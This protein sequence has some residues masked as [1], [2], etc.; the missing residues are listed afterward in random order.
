M[1]A[2][3]FGLVLSGCESL[4]R[5]GSGDVNGAKTARGSADSPGAGRGGIYDPDPAHL[6]NRLHRHLFVRVASDGREQGLDALDPFLWSETRYLI[7]GTAHRQAIALL[8]EFL[9]VRGERLVTDALK[10]ALLQRDLLAVYD[11]LAHKPPEQ[12]RQAHG[13]AERLAAVIRRVTLTHAEAAALP[14]NY[15]AAVNSKAFA[16]E[17]QADRPDAP[18]LPGD[19]LDEEGSWVCVGRDDGEQTASVHDVSFAARSTFLVF[20]RLPGGRARTLEYLRNL[21][22]HPRLWVRDPRGIDNLILNA[23]APQFPAGTQ[24]AL[25]R[26]ALLIDAGGALFQSPLTEDVQLRFYHAQPEGAASSA[27]QAQASQFFYE[28]KLSREKLFAGQDGGLRAVLS[29]EEEFPQ[30]MSHGID[31]FESVSQDAQLVGAQRVLTSCTTCHAAPGLRSVLSLRPAAKLTSAKPSEEVSR[32]LD[33]HT[34]QASWQKLQ[35][36]LRPEN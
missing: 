18:F 3:A 33:W 12:Q 11:W 19:L 27:H 24:V 8:D 1:C 34:K 4:R 25:L 23:D 35:E 36:R 30:F 28:F 26:R 10:R 20:M 2:L 15:R 17:F 31:P 7:E 13:L 6:W 21:G 14:D 32:S 9:A 22:A 5:A 29:G 16:A